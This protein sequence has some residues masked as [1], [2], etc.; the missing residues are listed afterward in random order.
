[1]EG[2]RIDGNNILTVLD[3]IQ[4]V[5][6]YCIREQKPYLIECTTFRM[7]GH[8]EASGTKYVPQQLFDEWR[9]KDPVKEYE[10]YLQFYR[11]AERRQD[12]T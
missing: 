7:R 3:T 9:E 5:R 8:E 11:L 2:V 1:M 10:S 6:E 4:G 12:Y